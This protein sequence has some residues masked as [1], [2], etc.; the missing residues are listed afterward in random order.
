V[1]LTLFVDVGTARGV[2]EM[3]AKRKAQGQETF[4]TLQSIIRRVEVVL[5][6]PVG[7]RALVDGATGNGIQL[8]R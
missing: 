6:E 3:I 2:R 7:S 5:D 8:T 1:Q 4:F